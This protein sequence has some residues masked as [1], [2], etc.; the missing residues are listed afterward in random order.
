[1]EPV[2]IAVIVSH[3]EK[4]ATRFTDA[5]T[6]TEAWYINSFVPG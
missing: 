1:M 6:D 5:D 4:R 3:V 2:K